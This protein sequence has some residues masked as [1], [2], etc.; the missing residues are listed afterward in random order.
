MRRSAGPPDGEVDLSGLRAATGAGRE[1]RGREPS[2]RD[3]ARSLLR[4]LAAGAVVFL[5]G[6]GVL[7]VARIRQAE[8][9][10]EI[11]SSGPAI[12]TDP[13]IYAK[14]RQGDLAE[15]SGRTS[16]VVS[17]S[18][19]VPDAEVASLL[20]GAKPTWYLV[21]APRHEPELTR[22][23]AAWRTEF[24][25]A[26]IADRDELAASL[27]TAPDPAA[28]SSAQAALDA[29]NATIGALDG[30]V[31]V[32]FGAVVEGDAEA[33]RGLLGAPKVRIVD[34]VEPVAARRGAVRGVRPEE[35][36]V[37]HPPRRP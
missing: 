14:Q 17:F 15:R 27:Q 8:D 19:Y 20:G 36:Q 35:A 25:E 12:G 13:A 34:P 29:L 3:H 18:E 30:G 22:D 1:K 23:V 7:T 5:L 16:A 24:R 33:L 11:V 26:A 2:S 21:A 6:A 37:G 10:P 4:S 28:T 32:V 31:A 9:L